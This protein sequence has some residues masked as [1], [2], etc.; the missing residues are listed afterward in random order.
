LLSF[1][2][3]GLVG[4]PCVAGLALLGGSELGRVLALDDLDRT[5]GLLDRLAGALRRTGDLDGQLG[6]Q[7]ALAE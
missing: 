5:A 2:L 1:R 7:S 3:G 6:V 4:D